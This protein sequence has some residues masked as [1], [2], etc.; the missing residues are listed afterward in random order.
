MPNLPRIPRTVRRRHRA[1]QRPVER[2]EPRIAEIEAAG[3]R[4]L[5]LEEP[6]AVETAWL[7]ENFEFH[8]LDLEDVLST[9]QRPEDR[10]VRRLHVHRAPRAPL[11][12]GAGAARRRRAERLHRPRLHRDAAERAAEAARAPVRA[13]RGQPGAA[14]GV[15][16]QG[17]RIRALRDPLRA[18]RLLL[19]D[20]RQDRLQARPH[21]R[22]DL[23]RA[24][25]RGRRPRHLRREARDRRPTARSS[26]PSARRCAC[27]SGRATCPTTSRSTSTTSSTRPSA[28]GTSSTTTKRSSRPSSRPTSR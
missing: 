7:A 20:P 5:Q 2:S 10:R 28:S 11:Q 27:S 6:T 8:E 19:P 24:P 22:G 3:L 25:L 13:A 9:R 1:P 23:H 18:L 14:R 12:Q 26:S 15:L 4:W 17:L 21:A 16:R